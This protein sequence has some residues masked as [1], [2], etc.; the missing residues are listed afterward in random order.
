M[1]P[2]KENKQWKRVSEFSTY[3]EAADRK[4]AI[5]AEDSKT[6]VK[7]RRCGP[8]GSRFKVKI[9]HPDFVAPKPQ[10]KKKN[11]KKSVDKRSHK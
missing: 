6:L 7:I 11:N 5:L 9:W 4:D 10:S 8:A 2:N 1:I 3:E